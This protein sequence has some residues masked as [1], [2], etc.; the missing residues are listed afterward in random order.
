MPGDKQNVH[1]RLITII[2]APAF[3]SASPALVAFHPS[4]PVAPKNENGRE[5]LVADHG[6]QNH[7][8]IK[9]QVLRRG[10]A[11]YEQALGARFGMPALPAAFP[12]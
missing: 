5:T 2:R 11:D 1:G 7:F 6:A 10:D 4:N 9:G 3:P 8:G 12:R